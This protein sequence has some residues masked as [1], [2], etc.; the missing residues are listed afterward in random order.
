MIMDGAL[1]AAPVGQPRHVLDVGTGTGIWAM[2]FA[3][4]HP[5]S[6]VTGM[7][8][9]LIQP[10]LAA[11]PNCSFVRADAEDDWVLE[12]PFDYIHLRMMFICFDD[13]R[14]VM[15][16]AFES[17]APGGWI[18]YQDMEVIP[19]ANDGTLRGTNL[20]RWSVLLHEAAANLGKS[21]SHQ[22]L[23]TVRFDQACGRAASTM[24]S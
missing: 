5:E 6:D 21:S 14:S 7:D 8:L 22:T 1:T 13:H 11:P 20:Q 9:S 18:E 17:L 19:T 12:H 16:R 4:E 3:E 23:T 2:Q 10:Q 15:R 24:P